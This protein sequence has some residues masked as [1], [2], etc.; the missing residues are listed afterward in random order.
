MLMTAMGMYERALNL[1]ITYDEQ[2]RNYIAA[3][4]ATP[5]EFYT[6]SNDM[7]EKLEL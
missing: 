4:N 1:R 6:S 7:V 5:T 3:R 2:Y